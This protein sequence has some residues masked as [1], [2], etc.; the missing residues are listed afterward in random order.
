MERALLVRHGESVF[1]ARGLATGK[2]D[3]R[4]PLSELGAAQARALAEE[5][6]GEDID[7]GVTSE[8]ERTRQTADI[9]LA[10]RSVRRIVLAELNDPLYGSYEGG[11]LDAYVAW[12]LANDSAAEPPGGGEAR[13]TL[14]ARYAAGFRRILDRPD[15]TIF[16]VA[17]SLPIA[18]VLTALAGLDPSPRVPVVEYAKPHVVSAGELARAIARLE[19]WCKAPT[20]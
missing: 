17:H 11:P 4:C 5:I 9:A 20:W 3:V 1:G 10:E 16:V 8:L 2:V 18:Y 12:A 14:V 15:R 19:A 6:S 7:L 13:Q